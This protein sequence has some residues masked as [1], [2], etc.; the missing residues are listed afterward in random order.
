MIGIQGTHTTYH[1]IFHLICRRRRRH[2]LLRRSLIDRR[3]PLCCPLILI[4]QPL[5]IITQH[6]HRL[7]HSMNWYQ[8]RGRHF[9][10]RNQKRKI[11]QKSTKWDGL[12]MKRSYWYPCGKIRTTIS[13]HRNHGKRG[14]TSTKHLA[15]FRGEQKGRSL[16]SETNCMML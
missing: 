15:L 2:L 8:R 13:S 6:H 12:R 4:T 11:S 16:T 10:K 9:S 3:L 5:N 7:R 1:K 14:E